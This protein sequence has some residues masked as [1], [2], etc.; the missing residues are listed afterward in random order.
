[1]KGFIKSFVKRAKCQ[2]FLKLVLLTKYS[3]KLGVVFSSFARKNYL[4]NVP[5]TDVFTYKFLANVKGAAVRGMNN[6]MTQR[7]PIT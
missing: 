6:P 5:A 4:P 1:M 2:Q 7:D 3:A